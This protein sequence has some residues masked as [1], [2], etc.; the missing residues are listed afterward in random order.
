MEGQRSFRRRT[1]R[2]TT[3]LGRERKSGGSVGKR[4]YKSQY[5]DGDSISATSPWRGPGAVVSRLLP[6]CIGPRFE[7]DAIRRGGDRHFLA[8]SRVVEPRED[9]LLHEALERLR[10]CRENGGQSRC[11]TVVDD[12]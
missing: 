3:S 12:L 7:V 1:A 11:V 8:D 4:H 10:A 6:Q 5:R 2:S 9:A